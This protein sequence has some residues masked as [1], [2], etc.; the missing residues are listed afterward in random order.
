MCAWDRVNIIIHYFKGYFGSIVDG[1]GVLSV[2][3]SVNVRVCDTTQFGLGSNDTCT[4]WEYI[5][6]QS[7]INPLEVCGGTAEV[8]V[9]WGGEKFKV[10]VTIHTAEHQ[11][12]S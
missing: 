4:L 5:W 9:V 7:G 10:V 3:M 12:N 1:H 8:G 2:Q 11:S 6:S